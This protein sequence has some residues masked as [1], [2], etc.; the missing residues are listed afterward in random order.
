MTENMWAVYST[1]KTVLRKTSRTADKWGEVEL[2]ESG[3]GLVI[4][5]H[6]ICWWGWY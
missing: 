6:L 1:S 2:G 5:Y 3:A 4:P